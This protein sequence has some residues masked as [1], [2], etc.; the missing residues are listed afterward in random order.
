M[1]DMRQI[2]EG[3][4]TST[5]TPGRGKSWAGGWS[6]GTYRKNSLPSLYHLTEYR[7]SP[8]RSKW[9][10]RRAFWSRT[11]CIGIRTS[12]RRKQHA[13]VIK[14]KVD[15]V[16]LCYVT[17][18]LPD[19]LVLSTNW[20]YERTIIKDICTYVSA[21]RLSLHTLIVNLSGKYQ[22]TIFYVTAS[23]V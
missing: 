19:L 12:F 8:S 14:E 20:R 11:V 1:P 6:R 22:S 5:V 16:S 9:H 21:C 7:A 15:G 23:V 2:V 13:S 17:A 10:S 3:I 4:L 18:T